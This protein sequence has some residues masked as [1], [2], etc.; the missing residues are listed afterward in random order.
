[1]RISSPISLADTLRIPDGRPVSE[2]RMIDHSALPIPPRRTISKQSF[3]SDTGLLEKD[4][5][6]NGSLQPQSL[7]TVQ[8]VLRAI[9]RTSAVPSESE[10]TPRTG[11][12]QHRAT[13]Q[14]QDTDDFGTPVLGYDQWKNG[15]KS[16]DS[17]VDDGEGVMEKLDFD[18]RKSSR[19]EDGI[20]TRGSITQM[21]ALGRTREWRKVHSGVILKRVA[22]I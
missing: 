17:G 8:P 10:V 7:A 3:G 11:G 1:M 12:I 13:L 21:A 2:P 22:L 19:G 6:D 5:E 16:W 9:N 20:S 4:R 14:R 18:Q 15:D